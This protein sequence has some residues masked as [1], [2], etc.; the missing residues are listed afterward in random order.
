MAKDRS[1][2]HS[3]EK[4]KERRA[5]SIKYHSVE[6]KLSTLPI[7]LFKLKDI[8][9]KGACFFVKEDSAILEHLEV[10]QKLNM[11]YH[12]EEEMEPTT[13]FKSEIKHITKIEENSYKGHYLVGIKM[14][15]KQDFDDLQND[16][17]DSS[18]LQS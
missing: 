5:R 4:R 3:K 7:Y 14:L 1:A 10:G 6:M 11:R 13:V 17:N 18:I 15:K 2:K 8:S 9:S 12:S 16:T